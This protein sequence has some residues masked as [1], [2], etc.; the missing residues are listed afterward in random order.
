MTSIPITASIP[1]D[2]Y[3]GRIKKLATAVLPKQTSVTIGGTVVAGPALFKVHQLRGMS[4]SQNSN[5]QKQPL[6]QS[7][8]HDQPT[9]PE[10]DRPSKPLHDPAGDPTYE[11][12]QPVTEPTPNPASDPPPEIPGDPVAWARLPLGNQFL[13]YVR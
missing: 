2:Q 12:S 8:L 4:L 3:A 13:A 11:P 5:S 6:P 1:L 7:P 10:Y 9:P